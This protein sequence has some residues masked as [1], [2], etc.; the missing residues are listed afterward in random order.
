[1]TLDLIYSIDDFI[2]NKRD[3]KLNDYDVFFMQIQD[4][5]IN[6]KLNTNSLHVRILII[7]FL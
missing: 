2:F 3:Y 1:M 6:N 7:N 5:I 4:K